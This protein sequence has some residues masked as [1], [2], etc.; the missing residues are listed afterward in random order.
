[1]IWEDGPV[2]LGVGGRGAVGVELGWVLSVGNSRLSLCSSHSYCRFDDPAVWVIMRMPLVVSNTHD[3][4]GR[5]VVRVSSGI[6]G[7]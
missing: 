5:G 7:G 1:M 2:V 6:D 4:L 3:P